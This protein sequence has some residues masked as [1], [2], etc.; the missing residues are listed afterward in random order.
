MKNWL[1]QTGYTGYN[2]AVE[3]IAHAVFNT[4]GIDPKRRAET[5]GIPEF[6]AIT[7]AVKQYE[8]TDKS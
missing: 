7:D 6:L 1:T 8:H 2:V 5:L 3:Q 4:A